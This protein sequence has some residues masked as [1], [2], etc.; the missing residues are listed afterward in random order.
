MGLT[1][2]AL[3]RSGKIAEKLFPL[4][5]MRKKIKIKNSRGWCTASGQGCCNGAGAGTAG[6]WELKL[7]GHPRVP[8]SPGQ[9]WAAR[10]A[11][12]CPLSPDLP[13]P[14]HPR[15]ATLHSARGLWGG[16]SA[17]AR[18]LPNIEDILGPAGESRGDVGTLTHL[19]AGQ[20]GRSRSRH[21][22]RGCARLQP[23][24]LEPKIKT[25]TPFS[26]LYPRRKRGK[27]PPTCA[28]EARRVR[29]GH[30][31]A[32]GAAAPAPPALPM[33]EAGGGERCSHRSRPS[34]TPCKASCRAGAG[35]DTRPQPP[36]GLSPWCNAPGRAAPQTP[37][38]SR[39]PTGA[40]WH[41][42]GEPSPASP[43]WGPPSSA[44]G[45]HFYKSPS[46]APHWD[47]TSPKQSPAPPPRA[48]QHPS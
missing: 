19:P 37:S 7:G 43:P 34:Q 15:M 8:K 26:T 40:Q 20:R 30:G 31:G 9:R 44:P 27:Q 14:R 4:P 2:K 21:P 17:P 24:P 45:G 36:Q 38:S 23:Q 28:S 10:G 1:Q 11:R 12:G 32:G 22:A 18:G 46:P 6:C 42:V 25:G 35:L 33:N 47:P 41:L 16:R 3:T 13:A 39:L 5:N 29:G 48:L